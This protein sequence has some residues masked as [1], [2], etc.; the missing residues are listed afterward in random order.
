MGG[1][2]ELGFVW[3]TMLNGSVLRCLA[4]QRAGISISPS[5]VHRNATVSFVPGRL[6]L[7]ADGV[8]PG[9][10]SG[11]DCLLATPSRPF[12]QLSYLVKARP[13]APGR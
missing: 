9:F 6:G 11:R 7:L 8:F 1:Q 10:W 3:V 12:L 5:L 13:M 2:G 4:L